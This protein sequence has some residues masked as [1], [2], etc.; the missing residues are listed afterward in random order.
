MLLA[1]AS[2]AQAGTAPGAV[3]SFS[4]SAGGDG[5][6]RTVQAAIDAAVAAGV[7]ARIHVTA[8]IWRGV[9]DIPTG[10]P[11]IELVGDG[12]GRTVLVND[13]FAARINPVT[14]QPFGTFGSATVFVRG[15]DF[16]ASRLAIANDAGPVG[17][18][19]ALAV[20]GTRAA[21]E[22]VRLRGHQD[23]VY[24]QGRDSVSWFGDCEVEGTVDFI[25][26]AGTALFERCR[27]RSLGDGYVT[28]AATPQG[29]AFGLVFRDC[30]LAA[31]PGVRNV[32]LGRP[33]RD[34]ARVA[35]L[36]SRLGGHI[37]AAGW[38]DWNQPHRQA[39]AFFAEAGN[40]G[41][42]AATD[43][44][45][46]WSHRLDPAQAATYTRDAILG[47]WRPYE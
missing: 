21:F 23:T 10:A 15:D 8:G 43:A 20:I 27:I 16:R 26:G 47:D 24:L 39:S 40:T 37:L 2:A 45:A 7:P 33:W 1:C 22:H 29:R 11:P 35:F 17:Q 31:A 4:V 18:A 6:H 34:H 3:A 12:A 9:V 46:P 14:G 28:A 25:F 42:G 38:H 44:R 41:P 5:S 32:Y 13:H 30:E 19:V 36:D